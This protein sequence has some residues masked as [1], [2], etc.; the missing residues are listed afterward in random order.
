MKIIGMMLLLV[1]VAGLALAIPRAATVNP[2]SAT[3]ALALLLRA[4][5]K[6][7]GAQED[8]GF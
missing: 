2:R 4:V 3:A 5:G 8:L 7:Y 1:G 6:G